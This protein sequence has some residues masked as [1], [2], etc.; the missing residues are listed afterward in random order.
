MA[1]MTKAKIQEF[2]L[3]FPHRL[4]GLSN[5]IQSLI[6]LPGALVGNCFGSGAA[7]LQ[8]EVVWDGDSVGRSFINCATLLPH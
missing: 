2:H 4:K 7:R 6:T 3:D 5:S 8:L 1:S